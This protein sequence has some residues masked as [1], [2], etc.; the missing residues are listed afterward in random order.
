VLGS[1]QVS[2][3]NLTS[4]SVVVLDEDCVF[5]ASAGSNA[6]P[7]HN[8][9]LHPG[10]LLSSVSPSFSHLKLTPPVEGA[11]RASNRAIVIASVSYT[12]ALRTSTSE[13][14]RAPTDSILTLVEVIG[15]S[16]VTLY[17]VASS[18]SAGTLPHFV[19]P[20]LIYAD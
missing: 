18:T 11:G 7:Q 8:P 9:S 20:I 12:F 5:S 2:T 1:W 17:Q 3:C 10:L 6:C 13:K 16:Q 19:L 15:A 4:G 14:A